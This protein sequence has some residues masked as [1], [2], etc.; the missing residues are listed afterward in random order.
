MLDRN[1]KI[2]VVVNK[3]KN[4]AGN[5]GLGGNMRNLFAGM[6]SGTRTTPVARIRFIQ[7]YALYPGEAASGL[8]ALQTELGMS[9]MDFNRLVSTANKLK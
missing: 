4:G 9:D 5:L 3:D 7:S 1:I 2:N 8:K 6:G